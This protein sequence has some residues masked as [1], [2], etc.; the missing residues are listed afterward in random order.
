MVV[1]A[2]PK[3]ITAEEAKSRFVPPVHCKKAS[4]VGI[5]SEMHSVS[6]F[7]ISVSVLSTSVINGHLLGGLVDNRDNESLIPQLVVIYSDVSRVPT[8]WVYFIS[9][10]WSLEEQIRK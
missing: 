5:N 9:Y 3:D 2:L 6:E 10:I 1:F 4:A 7:G 8:T